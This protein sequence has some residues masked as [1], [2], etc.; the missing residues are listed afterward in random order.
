VAQDVL[1]N[2]IEGFQPSQAST[3]LSLPFAV[4][5]SWVTG[6]WAKLKKYLTESRLTLG[7]DFNVGVGSALLALSQDETDNFSDIL[8]R[9]R[10]NTA[11]S[12]SATN[13]VSLQSCH[14]AMLQFHVLTEIEVISG[15]RNKEDMERSS[16]VK[17]LNQR[18]DV[19]GAFLSDKQYILGLRRATMQVSK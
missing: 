7:G 13:A 1:L 4:E 3:Q 12:L 16:L 18:L 10:Q 14:D 19:L 9:L 6:K 8:D 17:S 5:A 11:K 15:I 2:Q